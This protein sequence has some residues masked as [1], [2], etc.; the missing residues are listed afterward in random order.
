MVEADLGQRLRAVVTYDDPFAS[1]KTLT[2]PVV[3]VPPGVT[4][5]RRATSVREGHDAPFRIAAI[6]APATGLPADLTVQVNVT[7]MGS[8]I[9][10]LLRSTETI[11]AESRLVDFVV[12][13]DNDVLDEPHGTVQVEILPDAAYSIVGTNPVSL[14]VRDND[15][16]AV[17]AAL[18][19]NGGLV[20]NRVTLRWNPVPSLEAS[21]ARYEVR[22]APVGSDLADPDDSDWRMPP[23][24]NLTITERDTDEVEAT[25]GGPD[26]GMLYRVEVRAVIVDSSD[27]SDFVYVYPTS[28]HPTGDTKVATVELLT[29]QT[30]G[31]FDYVICNPTTPNPSGIQL[32]GAPQPLPTDVPAGNII[33]VVKKWEDAVKWKD[34]TGNNIIRTSGYEETTACRHP[35]DPS[36]PRNQIAFLDDDSLYELCEN[37]IWRTA[38]GCWDY[39]GSDLDDALTPRQLLMKRSEAWNT[40]DSGGCSRLQSFFLHETGHTLGLGHAVTTDSVVFPL[41]DEDLQVCEPSVHDV[42]AMMANYQSR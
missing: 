33:N 26:A 6:G 5:T 4:I 8:F 10:G 23:D 37:Y 20:N 40:E 15:D 24:A 7:G 19:A 30:G 34:A 3:T 27:W 32:P 42:A 21:P 16:P 36:Q 13:T 31:L 9:S 17:P 41:Y 18:R 12:G 14:E 11:P 39:E 35:L 28:D 22:F 38:Y 25:L 2:S 1:N 29:F